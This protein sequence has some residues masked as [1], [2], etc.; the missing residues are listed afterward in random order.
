MFW[1]AMA[2]DV[3]RGR[4]SSGQERLQMARVR[5]PLRTGLVTVDRPCHP[6]SMSPKRTGAGS[7]R[8]RRTRKEPEQAGFGMRLR[9]TPKLVPLLAVALF[10]LP[11]ALDRHGRPAAPHEQPA[12]P[13]NSPGW[14]TDSARGGDVLVAVAPGKLPS[15]AR[16]QLEAE[17]CEEP[18]QVLDGGC[19]LAVANQSP[20]CDPPPG[21]PRKMWPKNGQCWMP[22]FKAAVTPTS[23]DPRGGVSVA[24]P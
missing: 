21:K 12:A 9:L 15:P 1:W 20:P 17:K 10:L 24:D 14:T 6:P 4:A 5:K 23:S 11:T 8:A 7:Q 2:G 19:W 13:A 3:S 16:G 18:A 22:V